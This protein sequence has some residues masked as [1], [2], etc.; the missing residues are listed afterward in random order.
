LRGE[1]ALGRREALRHLENR[2]AAQSRGVIAVLIACADH[3]QAKANDVGERMGDE[4]GIARIADAAG[5]PLGDAQALLDLAQ[6][7]HAAIGRQEPAVEF[8][9]DGLARNR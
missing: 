5:E 1:L 9:D 8:G 7:Q 2:V 4:I 3:Q 6:Q